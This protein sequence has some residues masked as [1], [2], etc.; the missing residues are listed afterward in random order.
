MEF[1]ITFNKTT[2]IGFW[3][4]LQ[5]VHYEKKNQGFTGLFITYLFY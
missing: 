1:L 4:K 5:I 3:Y 2:L